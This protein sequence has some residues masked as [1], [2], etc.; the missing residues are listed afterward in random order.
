[1]AP[2]PLPALDAC[3]TPPPPPLTHVA[4]LHIKRPTFFLCCSPECYYLGVPEGVG[5]I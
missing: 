1:M 3:P 5:P 2:I 4:S